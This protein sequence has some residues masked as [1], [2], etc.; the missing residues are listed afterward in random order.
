MGVFLPTP[1][2]PLGSGWVGLELIYYFGCYQVSQQLHP[3]PPCEHFVGLLHNGSLGTDLEV[4]V[5]TV[6]TKAYPDLNGGKITPHAYTS[7]ILHYATYHKL[8]G[9][10][11]SILRYLK[12]TFLPPL[13][14]HIMS[15]TNQNH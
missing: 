3:P 13:K 7:S 12:V 1:Q 14:L 11:Y 15:P 4:G 6:V 2:N 5:P 8:T 9:K 10:T